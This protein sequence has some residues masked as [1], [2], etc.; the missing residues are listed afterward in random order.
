MSDAQRAKRLVR[1]CATH[2]PGSQHVI[3]S[4]GWDGAVRGGEAPGRMH[5]LAS[6]CPARGPEAGMQSQD[7]AH[8][9]YVVRDRIPEGGLTCSGQK[10]STS[11]MWTRL[12]S[13]SSSS[14]PAPLKSLL[15]GRVGNN[16]A[17]KFRVRKS[18]LL[19]HLLDQGEGH[20]I[21]TAGQRPGLRAW[22]CDRG[23]G[24]FCDS[25]FRAHGICGDI[26]A[27]KY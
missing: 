9:G 14:R 27:G 18:N 25:C 1:F 23:P 7:L 12:A 24:C 16:A 5:A 8:R 19:P 2:L 10:S 22:C 26:S 6:P 15:Q 4:D 11:G 3:K 17:D 20:L 21:A 13:S